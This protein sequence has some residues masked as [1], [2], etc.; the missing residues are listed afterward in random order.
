MYPIA[1]TKN[2]AKGLNGG[3]ALL[4]LRE[5]VIFHIGKKL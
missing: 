3:I 1:T 4:H 2:V 5:L